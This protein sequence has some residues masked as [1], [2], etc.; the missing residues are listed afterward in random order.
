MRQNVLWILLVV[1]SFVIGSLYTKVTYLEK[2]RTSVP[3]TQ[4]P[5]TQAPQ[6]LTVKLDQVK[7]VFNKSLVKFGDDK[8]KL[9]LIEAADP[10]CPYCHIAAGLNPQLNKEV[11]DR[12]TL[13]SDGGSYVPPVPEMKKLVDSGKASF[14]WLYTP[15]HGNGEMGTKALYCGFEKGKFWDVHDKIMTK[16]GYDVLNNTVKNDKAKSAELSQFLAQ[17]F[18]PTAMKECLDSGKYDGR[19]N[20]DVALTSS[21]GITGTPGFYIN[22]TNFAGAYTWKEMESAVKL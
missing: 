22:E 4:Q 16:E 1:S 7:N 12:F 8:K 5:P 18:D 19:L 9:I 20:E 10:S 17:V 3:S 6:Q 21:I 11:G 14:A 15:G 13:V 2:G